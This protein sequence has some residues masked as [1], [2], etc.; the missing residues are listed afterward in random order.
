MTVL[1]Q[2]LEYT[3]FLFSLQFLFVSLHFQRKKNPCIIRKAIKKINLR[4][5]WMLELTEKKD[6]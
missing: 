2:L 5:I 4:I 3:I 1:G 6:K